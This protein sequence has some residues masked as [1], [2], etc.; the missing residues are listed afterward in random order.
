MEQALAQ[1]EEALRQV[2]PLEPGLALSCEPA[3][4]EVLID[5]VLQ[6]RCSDFEARV[7]PLAEGLHRVD[8][9]KVGLRPYEAQVEAGRARAKLSAQLGPA[10]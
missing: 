10:N 4:A 6:G 1:H 5:G 9:K 8:V 2:R 3:D 7:I